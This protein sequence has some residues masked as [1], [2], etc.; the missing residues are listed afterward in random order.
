MHT[1]ERIL[2]KMH[3][4]EVYLQHFQI[5]DTKK[6]QLRVTASMLL[7]GGDHWGLS[8]SLLAQ[9]KS[10]AI[11]RSGQ[12]WLHVVSSQDL[13]WMD[14]CTTSKS[15]VAVLVIQQC[16]QLEL[17]AQEGHYQRCVIY[18]YSDCLLALKVKWQTRNQ[19]QAGLSLLLP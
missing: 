19:D 1:L 7:A 9:I 6:D 10:V 12:P 8:S 14:C 18:W 17:K 2:L 3:G 16:A 13:L 15:N 11:S 5:A 4:K